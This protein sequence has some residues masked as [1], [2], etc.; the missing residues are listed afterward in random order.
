MEAFTPTGA[1]CWYA[2]WNIFG[3]FY[4]YFLLPETKGL[5]LEE[6][7]AVFSVSNAKHA[8]YFYKRMPH[9]L[10]QAFK[11]KDRKSYG[12]YLYDHEKLSAEERASRGGTYAAA[13]A[14]H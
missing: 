14:G 5:S 8:S 13:A 10:S 7:D 4:T 1:F 3:F 2:A 6:L 12:K 9:D 11:I